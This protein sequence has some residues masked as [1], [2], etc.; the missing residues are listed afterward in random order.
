MKKIYLLFAIIGICSSCSNDLDIAAEYQETTVV[1]GLLNQAD[2]VHYVQVFKGF[3]DENT[4]AL[5]IA[6]IPDSIYYDDSLEVKVKLDEGSQTFFLEKI[7]AAQMGMSR[8]EGIFIDSPNYV[9]RFTGILNEN[10]IYNLTITNKRTHHVVIAQTPIV[11][12]FEIIRPA[13]PF[14]IDLATSSPNDIQWRAAE[15]AKVYQCL[16]RF[17]YEEWNRNTPSNV[18]TLFI[19]WLIFN[20]FTDNVLVYKFDGTEFL[21]FLGTQLQADL[22]INRRALADSVEFRFFVGAADL[23]E[24]IRV[25]GSQSGITSLQVKPEYTNVTNGLGIFSSRYSKTVY[26]IRL[27]DRSLDSLT[28]GRFT[29]DLNFLN[30]TDCD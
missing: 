30:S 12:D 11:K 26:N 22:D 15:N 17:F 21:A 2:T 25:S 20:N 9:Y 3:L 14:P 24:Y 1:Y 19:D 7:D 23:Y 6:Q 27:S 28:C 13:E 4:N 18:D 10:A 5:H 16:M 29:R 8:N